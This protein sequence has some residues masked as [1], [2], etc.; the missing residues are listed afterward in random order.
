MKLTRK[1]QDILKRQACGQKWNAIVSDLHI[2]RSTLNNHRRNIIER[3]GASN[4]MHAIYIAVKSNLI[5]LLIVLLLLGGYAAAQNLRTLPVGVE[6]IPDTKEIA[7]YWE[8]VPVNSIQV[9][10]LQRGRSVETELTIQNLS[11]EPINLRFRTIP[12]SLSWGVVSSNWTDQVLPSAGSANI[13]ISVHV[14]PDA[15]VGPQNFEMEF[16][17]P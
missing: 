1:Q 17:E 9:P 8:G 5:T 16:Y 6:I 13:T 7:V 4:T 3:L 12:E 11:Y 2:S 15:P 14:N 10:L